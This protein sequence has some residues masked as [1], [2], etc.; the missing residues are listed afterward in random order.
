MFKENKP[1]LTIFLKIALDLFFLYLF[2]VSIG[3]MSHSFK[4]FGQSFAENLIQTTSNPFIGLAVGILVT[5]IIQSS[6]TTTSM[7]VAFASSGTLTIQNAI[8]IIMGANIGTAVTSTIVA[9]GHITRK[10]E[11]RR[12]FAGGTLHDTFKVIY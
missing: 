10:E 6:S 2:L 7:V 1:S 8:P 11:F 12:A 3:L 9:L 5:S 4:G